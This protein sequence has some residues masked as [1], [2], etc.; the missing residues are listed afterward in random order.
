MI[1]NNIQRLDSLATK[2]AEM[3]DIKGE[4]ENMEE[5]IVQNS[6]TISNVNITAEKN[7]AQI[8]SVSETRI[9]DNIQ[10]TSDV[11]DLR[12]KIVKNTNTFLM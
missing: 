1:E 10:T 2:M 12:D 7:S 6:D 3:E 11:A 9:A 4:I 8:T 5:E